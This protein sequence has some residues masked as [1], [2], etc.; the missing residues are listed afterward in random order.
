M[1]D[2]CS[3]HVSVRPGDYRAP[4][5]IKL[6]GEPSWPVLSPVREQDTSA[7]SFFQGRL[8]D[9]DSAQQQTL[10]DFVAKARGA[11][12][13]SV[14]RDLKTRGFVPILDKGLFLSICSLHVR[15]LA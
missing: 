3:C 2:T 1:S 5:W 7:R 15:G 10:F 4:L 8:L 13:D 12:S 6:R 9:M 14:A 11:S